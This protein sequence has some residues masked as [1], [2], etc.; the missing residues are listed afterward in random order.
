MELFIRDAVMTPRLEG[1]THVNMALINKFMVPYFF[2]PGDF[3][4]IPKR[5]DI[6][7]D[8]Y[9]FKQKAGKLKEVVFDDYRKCY[10]GMNQVNVL[11]FR[12]QV[13]E[14]R[15]F[16]AKNTPSPEQ[17]KN[18][19][20]MI[21]LGELLTMSTYA[22]LILENVKIYQIEDEVVEE[23][24]A[25]MIRDFANYALIFRSTFVQRDDQ[26]QSINRMIIDPVLD[27]ARFEMIW[28]TKVLALKNEYVDNA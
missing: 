15:K 10:E 28:E 16:L 12:E 22:Q 19:D 3:P 27:I 6:A 4:E 20:Y 9:L 25:F 2:N 5:N 14:L 11:K 26:I 8:A 1:T 18:V 23:I 21:A 13:E 7:D 17:G 24:F